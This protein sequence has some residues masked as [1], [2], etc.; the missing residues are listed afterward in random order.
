MA[1]KKGIYR[2]FAMNLAGTDANDRWNEKSFSDVRELLRAHF[3]RVVR[4]PACPYTSVDCFFGHIGM[5]L[6]PGELLVYFVA[7]YSDSLIVAAGGTPD[8][9]KGGAT[10]ESS[11]GMI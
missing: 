3:Q 9:N 10:W 7:S 6:D 2:V 11:S 4:H 8:P 1:G 5:A